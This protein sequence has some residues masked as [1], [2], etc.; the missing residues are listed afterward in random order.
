M[1]T[2]DKKYDYFFKMISGEMS[3]GVKGSRESIVVLVV[4]QVRRLVWSKVIAKEMER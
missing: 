3:A 4:N 1:S 2:M